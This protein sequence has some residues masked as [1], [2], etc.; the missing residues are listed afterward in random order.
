MSRGLLATVTATLDRAGIRYAVIGAGA[1]AAHGIARSTFD[2]DLFTTDAVT[3][4][5]RTWAEVAA[6]SRIQQD[7]RRGDFTDP[8]A[9]V[10]RLASAGERDIDVVVGRLRWHTDA[11]ER[12]VPVESAGVRMPVVTPPD[13][14][15]L[16]LYAGGPQDYWDIEQLLA[17]DDRAVI[18]AAVNSRIDMLS[19]ENQS[20]WVRI[21]TRP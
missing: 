15:L 10:I 2:L 14:I 13:L 12:A 5:Q 4:E 21:C 3:L 1:L 11:V 20:A 19:R 7:I 18:I 17:R 9:G 8:L 16:K 6:D